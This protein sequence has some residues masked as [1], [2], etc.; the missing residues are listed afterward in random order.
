MTSKKRF[1]K[2]NDEGELIR[3]MLMEDLSV[4]LNTEGVAEK[5][6]KNAINYAIYN[7][8]EVSGKY[9]GNEYWSFVAYEKFA[10]NQDRAYQL[11]HEH[12]V[13]RN[14]I[15]EKIKNLPKQDS[16]SLYLL[17]KRYVIAA[18]IT[19]DEDKLFNKK[20]EDGYKLISKMPKG[21]Y[22]EQIIREHWKDNP[23]ARYYAVNEKVAG[24]IN[25]YK[26]LWKGDKWEDGFDPLLGDS[27]DVLDALLEEKLN[28]YIK[29]M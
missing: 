14:I 2:S 29:N 24:N 9:E 16:L 11:V 17:F 10:Y 6:K 8:T 19:K 21:F 23:W 15:R 27:K 7:W 1:Q 18:V 4:I 20:Y 26:V 25:I 3:Q 13:P 12:I 22:E 5:V 28:K